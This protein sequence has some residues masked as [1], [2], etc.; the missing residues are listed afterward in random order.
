MYS[1]HIEAALKTYA[2]I[3]DVV[4]LGMPDPMW[5]ER[6]VALVQMQPN[7]ELDENDIIAFCSEI[8][9]GNEIPKTFCC[10][11]HIPRI[12]DGSPDYD[13]AKSIVLS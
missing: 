12:S 7:T 1:N 9:D 3:F 5:G 13:W 4:V 10:V 11:E 6:V 2:N 8:L